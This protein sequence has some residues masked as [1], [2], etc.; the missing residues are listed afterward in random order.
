MRRRAAVAGQF[1]FGDKGRLSEHVASL[2]EEDA[3][4]EDVKAALCPHAGLVYSGSVAGA[5]YSRMRFPDTFVL[6]G[7]NHTG[8]GS[9]VSIMSEGIWEVPTGSVS[10]DEGL[11]SRIRRNAPLV[12]EDVQAHMFEH[13]LEVQLPLILGL[14]GGVRIVPISVLSA[15]LEDLRAVGEGVARAVEEAGYPVVLL[16]STDM[17]HFVPDEEA[18]RK[19]RMAIDKVL[20]LDADGLYSVVR[21]E[22]ISMCGVLPTV[23]VLYAAKALGARDATLVK[24]ATSA[25]V[26]GDYESVVG[27]AGVIIK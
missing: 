26:S 10:I 27:Y 11:A 13:S 2:L 9:P 3:R 20:A 5:V 16:A 6:L 14:S 4:K 19:D 15:S 12:R 17:S 7:P 23:I 18:R 25:E 1:Y 22:G 24:Y 21:E 8:L